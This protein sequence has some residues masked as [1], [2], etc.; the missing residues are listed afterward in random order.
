MQSEYEKNEAAVEELHSRL[1]NSNVELAEIERIV[2]EFGTCL[3]TNCETFASHM[4]F[5]VL[6]IIALRPELERALLLYA[7]R[8]L[9]AGGYY[10]TVHIIE[11]I[12]SYVGEGAHCLAWKLNLREWFAISRERFVVVVEAILNE[13]WPRE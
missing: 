13:H 10:E 4:L 1:R 11:Y 5:A 3:Q 7:I 2:T 6:P 8:P 12:N 9:V